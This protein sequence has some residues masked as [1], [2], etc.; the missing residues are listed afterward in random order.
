MTEIK[1]ILIRRVGVLHLLADLRPHS[2]ETARLETSEYS[3]VGAPRPGQSQDWQ[4]RFMPKGSVSDQVSED[5]GLPIAHANEIALTRSFV[6]GD[7]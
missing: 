3:A 5:Q 2:A 1:R 4:H 7:V 6:L